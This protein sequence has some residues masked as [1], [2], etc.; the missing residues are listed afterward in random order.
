MKSATNIVRLI[1]RIY[2]TGTP[3]DY[4][5]VHSLQ[6]Q[7]KLVPLSF[8]GKEYTPP[9]GTVDPTIDMKTPVRDQVNRMDAVTY[10]TLLA[11]LMKANPPSAADAPEV[12]RFAKIGLVPGQDFDPSKLNADFVKRIPQVAFDRVLLQFKINEDI[13]LAGLHRGQ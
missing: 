6:D 9:G 13:K 2:C 12:A 3:E 7:F 5:A 11:Q 10:F 8:Y 1:A 4:A